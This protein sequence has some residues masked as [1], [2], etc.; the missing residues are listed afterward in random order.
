MKKTLK[1]MASVIVSL[2]LL[3]SVIPAASATGH[4]NYSATQLAQIE[5]ERSELYR[6]LEKKLAVQN[7]EEYIDQFS[8][9]VDMT[10]N[11]KY[12]PDASPAASENPMH[13][14]PNGGWVYGIDGYY[15]REA[16]YFPMEETASIYQ[17]SHSPSSMLKT[18]LISAGLTATWEKSKIELIKNIGSTIGPLLSLS[19]LMLEL[20]SYST[21]MMWSDIVIGQEGCIISALYDNQEMRTITVF[22]AWNDDP[23]INLAIYPEAEQMH[24]KTR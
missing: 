22:W 16:E 17:A 5:T 19:A 20:E 3:I 9:L 12:Y 23:H 7:A 1:R 2:A 4:A 10:I 11:Q 15:Q 24:V 14:A 8:Y 21:E 18:A 6:V 13:Y